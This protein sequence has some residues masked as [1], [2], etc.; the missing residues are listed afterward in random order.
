MK[1]SIVFLV[2]LVL[3]FV[4]GSIFKTCSKPSISKD[5]INPVVSIT[6]T[7]VSKN[8]QP[9]LPVGEKGMI[10]LNVPESKEAIGK[11]VKTY[12]VITDKGNT[13]AVRTEQTIVKFKLEPKAVIGYNGNIN[14]GM[15]ISVFQTWR[16]ET[17]VLFLYGLADKDIRIGVGESYLIFENTSL[18]IGYTWNMDLSPKIE[19]YLS[20]KF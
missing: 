1:R 20:L 14:I 12:I 7:S 2:I 17:D 13:L 18:G 16:F 10:Q 5:I 11:K 3:A 8:V 19:I 9:F 6:P 4:T 15:G